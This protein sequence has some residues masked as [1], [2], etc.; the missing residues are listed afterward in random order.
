MKVMAK[1]HEGILVFGFSAAWMLLARLCAKGLQRVRTFGWI[2][3]LGWIRCRSTLTVYLAAAEEQVMVPVRSLWWAWLL[4]RLC[5]EAL[6]DTERPLRVRTSDFPEEQGTVSVCPTAN[7]Q[8]I[9]CVTG[10]FTNRR[11]PALLS[12]FT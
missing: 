12:G 8:A 4:H 5:P 6:K 2:T 7:V 11:L 1:A 3:S 9:P 10:M